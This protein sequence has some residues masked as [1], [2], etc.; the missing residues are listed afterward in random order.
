VKFFT[1]NNISPKVTRALNL[2]LAPDDSAHHLKDKYAANT[3]D[4]MWMQD[5]GKEKGWV[6]ISGDSASAEIH[7]KWR[8]GKKQDIQYSF[9]SPLGCTLMDGNKRQNCSIASP[10]F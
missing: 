5:L 3:P 4:E 10:R 1:D 6:I 2:L 9:S 8:P 7:T